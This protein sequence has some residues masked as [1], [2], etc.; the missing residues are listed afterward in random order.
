MSNLS[1]A[2]THNMI[3]FLQKPKEFEGFTD[4]IDFLSAS[5]LRYAL[6]V[7]PTI[8]ISHMK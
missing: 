6:T 7:N 3:A 5:T 1:F 4:I 2:N 8:Y